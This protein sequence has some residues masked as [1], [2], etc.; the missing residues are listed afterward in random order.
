MRAVAL[1]FVLLL[2]CLAAPAAAQQWSVEAS[3]GAVTNLE[4]SLEVRQEGFETLRLD[5]DYE[6]RPFESP[7]YY[8]LRA[9]RWR[10][11]RGWEIELIHQ[12]IHLQDPPE[13]I[14]SFAISH[15]YNLLTLNRAWAPRGWTFRLGAGAVLAH[16]ESTVR[17]R[18]VPEDGGLLDSGY[19]LA[20]P[21]VQAGVG[22]QLLP[23]ERWRLGLEGKVTAA[24]AE[25]PVAG[26]E[27]DVPNVALHLLLGLGYRSGPLTP[28]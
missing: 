8:S 7:L 24:R 6:T 22:R 25:V 26:G 3:V 16:P 23:G 20:G 2:G 14:Q 4:T 18:R 15:G 10:D 9:G 27:A 13:E 17:G 21:V 5:A 12:K 11:R 28:P 19:H 1:S